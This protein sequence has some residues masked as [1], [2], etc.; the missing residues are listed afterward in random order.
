KI[1]IVED[2]RVVARDIAQQL[3]RIGYTVIGTTARGDEA[4]ELASTLRPSLVLMDIRL[5]SSID[6]IEAA[7]QIRATGHVPVVFLT[8]YADDHTVAR[9]SVA[10]PYGYL[11]KPFEDSQLRTTVEMAL[12]KHAADL[13]VE[14]DALRTANERIQLALRGSEI[15]TWEF[16]MPDGVLETSVVRTINFGDHGNASSTWPQV[17]AGWHPDDRD[18]VVAAIRA[19]LAGQTAHYEVECRYLQQGGGYRTRI[20]RGVAVRNAAGVP[21]RFVGS[22]VDITER[23]AIAES[24]SVSE[25]RYRNTFESAPVGF[26]HTDFVNRRILRVNQAFET[27]TGFTREEL[28]ASDGLLIIHPDDREESWA[29]FEQLE[30]GE[31]TSYA[32]RFRIYRKNGDMMWVRL[33]VSL[34]RDRPGSPPYA[35][36][37]VE[38]ISEPQRLE[39]ALHLA[40]EAAES[41]NRAKDEFLANV[42]HEIRTPMNAILGMTELVLDTSLTEPQRQSLRTVKS[43]ASGLLAIINDLLDFSKIEADK[44]ELDPAQFRLRSLL[45]D[46]MRALAMRAHRKGLELMCD[47]AQ[48]VPDALIGD[49]GRL[50]QV[51]INLVGNAIK[52]T[53]HGEVQVRVSAAIHGAEATLRFA[54]RDTGI[55][56]S[57]E[58]QET[59][60]RAFEQEDM[61]T[62]RRF[63]GT[64]LGLTIASRLVA[65]M[66]GAI[67]V[68]SAPDRGSTFTFDVQL[69]WEDRPV[70]E[71]SRLH[72][73]LTNARVLVVDDNAANREILVQWLTS[74]R[75]Q[76]TAV[77]DGLAAMDALWHGVS[78]RNPYALVLLD[79]RMPDTDGLTLAAKIRDR[80][81]L[82]GARIVLLTSGDRPGDLERIKELRIDAHV[83]K[84]VPEDELLETIVGVMTRSEP[85]TTPTPVQTSAEVADETILPLRVLV[86]EDNSFNARL[87]HQLLASRGH[88]VR[89]AS[90]GREALRL[91]LTG[92]FELLLLDLHMP[93]LDGFGVIAALREA[94]RATGKHLQVIALT[95]RSRAEDRQRC[96]D[97]GM[98]DFLAKPI[99]AAALWAAIEARRPAPEL[100]SAQV[101]L[102]ACGG[103]PGIL[104]DIRAGLLER[105]PADLTAIAAALAAGNT[106]QLREV[107]HGVAGMVSAFSTQTA[108]IASELEDTA[109]ARDLE[110]AAVIAGELRTL[111]S[112]LVREVPRVTIDSLMIRAGK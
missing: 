26:V 73:E 36:A 94:E 27:M 25:E 79:A 39:H 45:G 86:A 5:E 53:S 89:I 40:K 43:A 88:A 111:A 71:A 44:L 33:N 77:S 6:G 41:S 64:G 97:A 61:S 46:T 35:V 66:G 87:L 55:G 32:S 103:D 31:L 56:I 92:G 112:E 42:S 74:W 57:P 52:F 93:E 10:E 9:A 90:D 28:L 20:A 107:A 95:A 21:I 14:A 49:A 98:D 80:D 106:G 101:L 19:Y 99:Q 17:V 23:V 1:L 110:R 72:G 82:A 104:D 68:E 30:T 84:P 75:M 58:K 96:L 22:S 7:T 69:R 12:H 48:D 100:I 50:R 67:Q 34:G 54:V 24:L 29:R 105:L 65:M 3:E 108:K 62:T 85:R 18:R 38:D 81:E 4:I 109:A 63:G 91:A 60:F 102:A 16:E 47:V 70:A 76:P 13:R 37:I 59:I 51:L 78:T 11:L 8:A 15:A 2:D 83:L